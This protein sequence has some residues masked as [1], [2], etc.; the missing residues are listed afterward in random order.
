MASQNTA[1]QSTSAA[2]STLVSGLSY[3]S[4]T[5]ERVCSSAPSAP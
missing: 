3:F 1:L 5:W 2:V 4:H